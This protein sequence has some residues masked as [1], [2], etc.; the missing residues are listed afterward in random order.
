VN[1][2]DFL[3]P[4]EVALAQEQLQEKLARIEA[5]RLQELALLNERFD[6]LQKQAGRDVLASV[7]G[8]GMASEPL[9]PTSEPMPH[10]SEPIGVTA[11]EIAQAL[12]Y[13]KDSVNNWVRNGLLPEA[14]AGTGT[15]PYNPARY[16]LDIEELRA[17]VKARQE[18]A[19]VANAAKLA[20]KPLDLGGPTMTWEKAAT[21]L[22]I[23][24]DT[25]RLYIKRGFLVGGA[26]MT[27]V[28]SVKHYQANRLKPGQTKAQTTTQKAQTAPTQKAVTPTPKD[29]EIE[30]EIVVEP[31][32]TPQLSEAIKH[33]YHWRNALPVLESAI[34]AA[35]AAGDVA[36]EVAY[37]TTP[38]N[39][40]QRGSFVVRPFGQLGPGLVAFVR[41][42]QESGK[43][44]VTIPLRVE[45]WIKPMAEG[46]RDYWRDR[47]KVRDVA[48]SL[49]SPS[50]ASPM[51][52]LQA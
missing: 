13:H 37:Q 1:L 2:S 26:G 39:Y 22:G 15:S 4:S 5:E 41:A 23:T 19:K 9:P 45:S 30:A 20:K 12:G 25:V 21:V 52:S 17:K 29:E 49:P 16:V 42:T 10:T 14:V 11:R 50:S 46:L 27:T 38:D 48:A 36:L 33:D 47:A 18:A 6:L 44:S 43:W 24:R 31:R 3:T 7:L 34:E 28:E 32:P 51:R 40:E 8:V 35:E